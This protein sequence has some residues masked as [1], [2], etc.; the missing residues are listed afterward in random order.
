LQKWKYSIASQESCVILNNAAEDLSLHPT[1]SD[2]LEETVQNDVQ[3]DENNVSVQ[4]DRPRNGK[5]DTQD[6]ANLDTADD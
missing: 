2:N 4:D 5:K 3:D 6:D 1:N